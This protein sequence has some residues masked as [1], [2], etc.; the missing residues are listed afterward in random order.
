MHGL[1]MLLLSNR[2]PEEPG[3]EVIRQTTLGALMR[4]FRPQA[5]GPADAV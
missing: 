1:V 4:G 3:F 2:I 5:G